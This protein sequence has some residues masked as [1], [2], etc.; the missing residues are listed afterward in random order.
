VKDYSSEDL[1]Q[2]KERPTTPTPARFNLMAD[3]QGWH[4]K[5]A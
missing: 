4:P 1:L 3:R 2:I 5:A